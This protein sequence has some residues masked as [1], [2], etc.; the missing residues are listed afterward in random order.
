MKDIKTIYH[1]ADIHCRNYKRHKEYKAVFNNLFEYIQKNLDDSSIIFLGGDIVH[2]KNDMSPELVEIVSYFLKSCAD[3]LPTILITG[4]HDLNLNNANRMDALSPIVNA[5][6][7]PNLHYWKDSG[8]YKYS[9]LTFSVLSCIDSSDKWILA[10]DISAPVK[11][12]L[13]H[14][15]VSSA[16]T[17]LNWSVDDNNM[18]KSVFDGFDISL[19][20]DIHKFQYID[21]EKRIAYPGSLIQ[22]NYGEDIIHG[23]LVWDID[24]RTSKFVQIKNDIAYATIEVENGKL[25]TPKE[26]FNSLPKN[27]KLRLKHINSSPSEIQKIIDILKLK[28]NLIETLII[29]VNETERQSTNNILLEN[30]RDINYQNK[31]ITKWVADNENLP[32]DM[33]DNIC[34]LNRLINSKNIVADKLIRNIIWKLGIFEFSNMFSYGENNI[35]DFRDYSGIVGIFAPNASGKSTLLDAVTYCLF[36]KCSR[37]WRANDIINNSKDEFKCKLNIELNGENYIIER[38]GIK[39]PKNNHVKVNVNFNKI[40]NDGSIINL[41]GKDR[42][43]TNKIIREYFGTYDD[44]LLTALSTQNDNKNFIFKSQRE[45]KDLLNSFLDISIFDD[46]QQLAKIELKEKMLNIKNLEAEILTY[47]ISMLTNKIQNLTELYTETSSSYVTS[48]NA[49]IKYNY[50]IRRLTEKIQNI[51]KLIDIDNISIKLDQNNKIILENNNNINENNNILENLKKDLY[52]SKEILCQIDIDILTK[53]EN[54]LLAL[55]NIINDVKNTLNESLLKRKYIIEQQEHLNKHEYDPDCQ[56]C[57]KNPFVVTARRAI[58]ELPLIEKKI[59]ELNNILNESQIK[60]DDI[61]NDIKNDRDLYNKH[62]KI[63]NEINYQIKLINTQQESLIQSNKN[64]NDINN[65]YILEID[66]YNKQEAAQVNN[67][68]IQLKINEIDKLYN[69]SLITATGYNN[70]LI[71]LN[72]ELTRLKT[73]YDIATQRQLNLQKLY[74]EILIYEIYVKSISRDGVPHLIL[75]KIL[76]VIEDEVNQILHQLVDFYI[77]LET[78]DKN[79]DCYIHYNNEL[80]WPVELAS[81]MERFIISVAIRAA[82]INITSLPRP[83]FLAIDEGFGVLDSDKL[84]SIDLLFNHL[85]TQFDFILCISHLDSMKDLAESVI[86]INKD[87]CGFSKILN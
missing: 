52:N 86:N 79:I 23:I 1:I 66:R 37:T 25:N 51:D 54:E 24:T 80:N 64:L 11:I 40:L 85:R 9:N 71:E 12:A 28:F 81:G 45:R 29:K 31:L 38:V 59:S 56:Y 32:P 19:L 87:A 35:I 22:Q 65:Q 43:Q 21:E 73:N 4:N 67:R 47:D 55:Y 42:E 72:T 84:G 20:G 8:V 58:E 53:K 75:S 3:L 2:S 82:L 41:N 74:D 30:I 62:D 39:N 83:N 61:T 15:P 26:Y 18:N 76:P 60:Y 5:L 78:D 17:D 33:V 48:N 34:Q 63:I 27:I 50:E 77:T 10:K 6:N 57:I 44:F 14:G 68:N 36:D 70:K 7:H 13:Y 69:T 16:L 46:L 49:A